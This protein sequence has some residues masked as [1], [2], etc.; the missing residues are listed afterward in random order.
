[1]DLGESEHQGVPGTAAE[2]NSQN[3]EEK[4]EETQQKSWHGK[5]H[6]KKF[7][8]ESIAKQIEF[9]FSPSNLAKDGFMA[10]LVKEDPCK[11]LHL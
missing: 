6:V 1:M 2:E 4:N 8:Y 9:Y 5:K 7:H 3:I 11:L 10:K